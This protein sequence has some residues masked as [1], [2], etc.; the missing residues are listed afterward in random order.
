LIST[1]LLNRMAAHRS[2]VTNLETG[3]T[4]VFRFAGNKNK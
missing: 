3:A 4:Q 1:D 2:R